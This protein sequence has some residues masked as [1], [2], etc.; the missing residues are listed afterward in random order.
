MSTKADALR[1]FVLRTGQR[2]RTRQYNAAG[3][4]TWAP[5]DRTVSAC[6]FSRHG[7]LLNGSYVTPVGNDHR[8]DV[9]PSAVTIEWLAETGIP[10]HTTV[11]SDAP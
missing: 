11:Y 1:W 2:V 7:V 4:L 6:P 9:A 10:I 3:H 5:D 8:V